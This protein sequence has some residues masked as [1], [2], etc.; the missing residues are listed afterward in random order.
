MNPLFTLRAIRAHGPCAP[1]W[2][3]GLA[4]L[5]PDLDAPI[6]LGDIARSNG[7]MD[8]LWCICV[9]DWS[10]VA[11]RRAVIKG[12]VL[13]FVRRS[14][15]HTA[16]RRVHGTVG[17]IARWCDGDDAV[18]LNEASDAAIA[19]RDAAWA[20]SDAAR[21]ASA[22][23]DAERAA[24]GAAWAAAWAASAA[25]DAARAASDASDAARAAMKQDIITAFPPVR[26]L[27]VA[28]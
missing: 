11:V 26:L 13:P 12:A 9:L 3:E 14:L 15:A 21:A 24:N 7:V 19:A 1:G 5:G 28:P 17:A 4:N 16:D 22:S 27:E 25:S 18:D 10:D 6:S 20:A 8:A 2:A 23:R